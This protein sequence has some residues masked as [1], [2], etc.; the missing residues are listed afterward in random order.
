[1]VTFNPFVGAFS[2][3]QW[4]R[5]VI[6][7]ARD[8]WAS[9]ARNES[10]RNALLAAQTRMRENGTVICAVSRTLADRVAGSGEGIVIPNAID[11]ETWSSIRPAPA[12][13][14]AL[15]RPVAAYAGTIDNR[16][17]VSAL[18]TLARSDTV[19][20]IAIIGL[21]TDRATASQL[22]AEPTIH[23]LGPMKQHELAGALMAA[24]VCLLFHAVTELTK[25]MSPLKLYEYLASGSPIAATDLPPVRGVH[26]RVVLVD[27]VDYSSAVRIALAKGRLDEPQR[28]ELVGANSWPTRHESLISLIAAS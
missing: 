21:V 10:L 27:G 14:L 6:Y 19:G 8:D 13:M 4:C 12:A 16:L 28:L 23:L 7:Y 9:F 15:P 17:D 5:R 22:A 20:S 3:L 2:P 24:D 18:R 1:M 11:A 26:D 25:A